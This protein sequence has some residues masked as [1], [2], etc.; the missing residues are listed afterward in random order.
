MVMYGYVGLCRAVY[1]YVGLCRAMYGYVRLCR[2]MYGYVGREGHRD[3]TA[4]NVLVRNIFISFLQRPEKAV[5]VL[6][7]DQGLFLTQSAFYTWLVGASI[8]CFNIAS[9]Q[10]VFWRPLH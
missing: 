3:I 6:K 5:D 2:A 8:P 4:F 7:E 1:G 9:L 10:S